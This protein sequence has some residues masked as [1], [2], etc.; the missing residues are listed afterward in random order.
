MMTIPKEV[1][2]FKI[3]SLGKDGE[4]TLAQAYDVLKKCWD[5]GSRDRELGLR[6]MFISW[7][8]I[9]E[10]SHITGFG[11]VKVE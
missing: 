9:V 1:L 10:P 3:R 7:F 6:L 8:G 2:E 4:A 5:D 11:E